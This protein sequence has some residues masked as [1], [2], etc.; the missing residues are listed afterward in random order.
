MLNFFINGYVVSQNCYNEYT[1]TY[2]LMQRCKYC[3]EKIPL[4]V[5][6]LGQNIHINSIRSGQTAFWKIFH[7]FTLLSTDQ[8]CQLF[9]YLCQQLLLS[10]FEFYQIWWNLV[11]PHNIQCW[12]YISLVVKRIWWLSPMFSNYLHFS[13]INYHSLHMLILL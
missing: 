13:S 3:K 6:M 12:W 9:C 1:W 5:D 4:E 11:N 2:Y 7:Q 10:V 8:E